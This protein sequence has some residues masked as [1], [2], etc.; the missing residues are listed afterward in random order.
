MDYRVNLD[1][2]TIKLLCKNI[3][4]KYKTTIL[5]PPCFQPLLKHPVQGKDKAETCG[6]GKG[7]SACR[8]PKDKAADCHGRRKN[9]PTSP[10]GQ[11]AAHTSLVILVWMMNEEMGLFK[12]LNLEKMPL[13][14]N[15]S[16]TEQAAG[17]VFG[18]LEVPV[19]LPGPHG[20]SL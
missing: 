14:I 11:G 1:T 5:L 15:D 3:S 8:S 7:S 4:V 10:A 6:S 19:C 9:V 12:V 13:E 16:H 20:A 17:A 2:L 18:G